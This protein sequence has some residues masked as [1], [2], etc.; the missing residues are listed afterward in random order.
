VTYLIKYIKNFIR[1]L[2]IKSTFNYVQRSVYSNK[3]LYLLILCYIITLS[4]VTI[5]RERAFLTSGFDLGIFNQSFS[6][7]LFD[8]KLFYSTGDLSFNPDGSFFGVHFSPILFILLPFYAIYPGPENLL[9]MQTVILALGA[10]PIY[11]MTRDKLGK[12]IGLSLALVYLCSPLLLAI[13]LYDFHLEAF[14]STFFLFSIYYLEKEQWVKFFGFFALSLSTIEFAP[15]IGVFLAFYIGILNLQNKFM[16]HNKAR[17]YMVLTAIISIMWF[18]FALQAKS[19]FNSSTSPVPSPFHNILQN[20]AEILTILNTNISI[21]LSYVIMLFAPLAFLPLLAPRPLIMLLPWIGASF[22][23]IYP[24]Y[25]SVYYQYQGFVI[26]FLFIALPK[27]IECL[28]ARNVQKIVAVIFIATIVSTAYLIFQPGS[29]WN[30][31]PIPNEKT[32][33]IHEILALI[34]PKASILTQNDLFPHVS[35][36]A[37]AYMYL[38]RYDNISVEYI[39]VDVTSYWYS[40]QQSELFGERISPNLNTE[41]ALRNGNYGIYAA[42]NGIILLKR[43][44]TADPI[45]YKPYTAV[46][47]YDNLSPHKCSIKQDN[48]SASKQIL[49]HDEKD[50]TGIFWYGPYTDLPQGLYK[51]T[52]T[53]K[54]SN[55][56]SVYESKVLTI[57][58]TSS[59][60]DTLLAQKKIHYMDIPSNEWFNITLFVGLPVPTENIE[61]RGNGANGYN[62]SLD[63]ITVE[64]ILSQPSNVKELAFDYE[65][66]KVTDNGV[67]S[68]DGIIT[69]SVGTG[70]I[71][72]GPYINLAKGNYTTNFWLKL[73]QPA[74]GDL[75]NL[76]ITTDSGKKIV[77][78]STIKSDDFVNQDTWQ[79]FEVKFSLPYDGKGVEFVG[80]NNDNQKAAISFLQVELYSDGY[81]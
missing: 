80:I 46:F 55:S 9:V 40:W 26:P 18:I 71:W 6:T 43:E 36:R 74:D 4:A 68:E 10:L 75:I 20:P 66:L 61:F 3:T 42:T 50:Q 33:S 70:V 67:I 52:F 7:T 21:K 34:P 76:Y 27:A 22:F 69:Q 12:K 24:S 72:Y 41:E 5:L 65:E 63:T 30:Y 14:T 62:I 11:W 78:M 48:T 79:N 53:V 31:S 15:I 47:N 32:E 1:L 77:A 51:I 45:F 59:A 81:R 39:L 17:K 13:N 29:P 19:I 64:Q 28:N 25:Y 54:V 60:G 16:N 73:N 8:N 57:D 2:R 56:S 49:Y 44:F 35:N 37:D 23:S 58:V 38:P